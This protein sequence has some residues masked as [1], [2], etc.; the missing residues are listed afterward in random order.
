MEIREESD[1][2]MSLLARV[3]V[4]DDGAQQGH[5]NALVV[6]AF[7]LSSPSALCPFVFSG[8]ASVAY[9]YHFGC[10]LVLCKNVNVGG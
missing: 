10:L 3:V 2:F 6:W 9:D 1:Y 8:W 7:T 4:V 5:L